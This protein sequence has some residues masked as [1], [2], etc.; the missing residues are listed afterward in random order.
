MPDV[1]FDIIGTCI[2]YDVML[3]AIET[4]LGSKL[5]A[6]NIGTKVFFDA[7]GT[8][9]ER[10]F[11]YLSQIGNYQ[12]T[13]K[14]LKA[15]FYRALHHAGIPDP[16]GLVP[17]EDLEYLSEQWLKLK[18]RPELSKM[19]N[20]LRQ[21]GFTIW[22]LTDGDKDR[23]KGYFNNS[24]IEMPDE[25]I[26]SCDSLKIG[27]PTP[28]VYKFMLNK[29]P[30]KGKD[31][32]FAAAH[33]WDCCAAKKAGFQTAWTNVYEK[34]PCTDIFGKPDLICEGLIDMAESI[35]ETYKSSE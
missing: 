34:F 1:V 25:N 24:S 9:C 13:K 8:A 29:I 30:G 3:D 10:D 18:A 21:E 20:L 27:K 16:M 26:V 7:W 4:R 23:V 22:C 17:D 35:I 28:E 2:G 6:Y 14:I 31:A 33:M 15:T 32:W 12:P 5:K 11:S 19:W